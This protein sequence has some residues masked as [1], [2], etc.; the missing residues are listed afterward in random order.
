MNF[1]KFYQN[2]TKKSFLPDFYQ[3]FRNFTKSKKI[4]TEY[5]HTETPT[6]PTQWNS[7]AQ[8]DQVKHALNAGCLLRN[9]M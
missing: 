6:R 4:Y 1:K 8:W 3:N 2:F 9:L 5:G 7:I